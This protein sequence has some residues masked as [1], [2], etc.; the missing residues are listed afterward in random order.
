[1]YEKI[2]EWMG[3]EDGFWYMIDHGKMIISIES[4]N[5]T[6]TPEDNTYLIVVSTLFTK[7]I[8]NWKFYADDVTSSQVCKTEDEVIASIKPFWSIYDN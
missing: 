4:Y 7:H 6:I 2:I 8:G 1:M 3:P 5:I